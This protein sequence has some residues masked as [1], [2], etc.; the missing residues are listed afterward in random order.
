MLTHWCCCLP[1]GNGGGLS[2][3]HPCIVLCHLGFIMLSGPWSCHAHWSLGI[4]CVVQ[5]FILPW[6]C[7]VNLP[8]LIVSSPRLL[9]HVIPGSCHLD[10]LVLVNLGDMV[11][12]P[13]VLWLSVSVGGLVWG[14]LPQYLATDSSLSSMTV[15][16]HP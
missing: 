13:C 6:S 1:T 3:C 12:A 14:Y 8:V 10:P 5:L 11:P 9:C 2:L 7:H 16:S 15:A 4:H